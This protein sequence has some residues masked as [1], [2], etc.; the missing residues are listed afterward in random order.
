MNCSN[1]RKAYRA[2]R[3]AAVPDNM[4]IKLS[5]CSVTHLAW[6]RWAPARPAAYRPRSADK[7]ANCASA[8]PVRAARYARR[9]AEQESDGKSMRP[10][11]PPFDKVST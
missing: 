11:P 10:G 4:P 8:P 9:W 1:W 7:T 2:A 3:P 6:A 5:V